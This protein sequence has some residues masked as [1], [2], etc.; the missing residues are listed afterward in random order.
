MLSSA[1][2]LHLFADSHF[3][4]TWKQIASSA[5]ATS[6]SPSLGPFFLLIYGSLLRRTSRFL[7]PN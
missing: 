7:Q 3:A 2:G 4:I 6:I 5:V 1:Q